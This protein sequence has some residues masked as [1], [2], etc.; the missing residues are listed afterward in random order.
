MELGWVVSGGD[1]TPFRAIGRQ[2]S[3]FEAIHPRGWG[4]LRV[5]AFLAA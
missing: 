1:Q 2:D 5:E 4:A 3:S